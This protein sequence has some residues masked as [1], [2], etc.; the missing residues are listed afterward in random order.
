M[1]QTISPKPLT[2]RDLKIQHPPWLL[3]FFRKR[4]FSLY[5]TVGEKCSPSFQLYMSFICFIYQFW[6]S[7]SF[8]IRVSFLNLTHFTTHHH[9]KQR[10]IPPT[11]RH[12]KFSRTFLWPFVCGYYFHGCNNRGNLNAN[13][14]QVSFLISVVYFRFILTLR[15]PSLHCQGHEM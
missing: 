14:A 3:A 1:V 13:S 4:N 8:R 5:V 12:M 11:H 2:I 7:T 15:T 6:K 10:P 9:S